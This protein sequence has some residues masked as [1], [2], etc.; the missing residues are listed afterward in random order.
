[1]DP[2]TSRDSTRSP[3]SNQS[4]GK[5]K[6]KRD[7]LLRPE[8]YGPAQAQ[9]CVDACLDQFLRGWLG[10]TYEFE[11]ICVSLS[12]DEP[13]TDLWGLTCCDSA[14]CG[15]WID[16]AGKSPNVNSVINKCQ[17]YGFYS[18]FDPGPPPEGY[19]ADRSLPIVPLSPSETGSPSDTGIATIENVSFA[20]TTAT[21][22]SD[23]SITPLPPAAGD[24]LETSSSVSP[25]PQASPGE[26]L[27]AG[28]RA[29]I[30]I[31]SSIAIVAILSLV[32]YLFRRRRRQENKPFPATL[33]TSHQHSRLPSLPQSGCLTPLLTTPHPTRTSSRNV[34]L[35]PPPRLSDRRFLQAMSRPGTT[36]SSPT[37]LYPPSEE[38][39]FPVSPMSPTGDKNTWL[40]SQGRSAHSDIIRAP[41]PVATSGRHPGVVGSRSVSS[42]SSG[43]ASPTT[44]VHRALSGAAS[45][46]P[47]RGAVPP[48]RPARPH[49]ACRGEL[50]P[51]RAVGPPPKR[52]LPPPPPEPPLFGISTAPPPRCMTTG[53]SPAMVASTA[54]ER[55][56]PL[57]PDV[58]VG[59]ALPGPPRTSQ[60][61]A[62]GHGDLGGAYA[63]D[64]MDSWGSWSGTESGLLATRQP[65]VACDN[66]GPLRERKGDVGRRSK[67]TAARADPIF[68]DLD[69][70]KL[71]GSY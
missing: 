3:V 48:A 24:R 27:S 30:G 51:L 19:C 5:S 37:S 4:L 65:S 61:P 12:S 8:E 29:A 66:L 32:I 52:A 70:E 2:H 35:I 23:P 16:V 9:A 55:V 41:S 67:G 54:G 71:G 33:A 58:P 40:P 31:C 57:C 59:L 38:G 47:M 11:D 6:E 69:L 63:R 20:G 56:V 14:A 50:E 39:G 60:S 1:M 44:S 15:V 64:I 28:G 18:I 10:D 13:N 17:N 53:Y 25:P 21:G 22:I 26:G 46:P 45:S 43:P 34:P 42:L 36:R 49:D 7:E 68:K 62:R